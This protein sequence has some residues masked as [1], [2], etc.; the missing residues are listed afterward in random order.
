MRLRSRR[1]HHYCVTETRLTLLDTQAL[2]LALGV[3]PDN[4][5]HWAHR[6]PAEL[7]RRGTG[8]RG[9]AIYAAEDAEKLMVRMR[10]QG[11]ACT[12]E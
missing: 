10:G 12:S 1:C 3:T 5:R 7:P 9:I 11:P 8:R 6:H 4:I 2:A